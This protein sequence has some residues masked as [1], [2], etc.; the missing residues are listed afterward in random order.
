MQIKAL[1]KE[2]QRLNKN[3][4][5]VVRLRYLSNFWR[6]LDMPLINCEISLT[7]SWSKNWVL[8]NITTQNAAAA[9]GD[10]PGGERIDAAK[11]ATFQITD[12]KL[13]V[14]I[15]TLSEKDDNNFFWNN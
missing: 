10:N 13:Y 15:V 1:I 4:E 12:T 8:T 2:T 3:L 7:L 5:I 6:S 9:H 11:N 14:P